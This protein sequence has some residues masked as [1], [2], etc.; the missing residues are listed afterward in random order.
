MLIG[1]LSSSASAVAARN[2]QNL[3]IRHV[4]VYYS[5]TALIQ[6]KIHHFPWKFTSEGN[7]PYRKA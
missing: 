1:R 4:H 6:D 2:G 5:V 3:R 7:C